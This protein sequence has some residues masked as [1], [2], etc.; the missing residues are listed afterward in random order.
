MSIE[1]LKKELTVNDELMIKGLI[2]I[3]N[4]QTMDE[5][6][7]KDVSHKNGM[8]FTT[9]DAFILTSFAQFYKTR[10]FLSPKQKSI[11]R[12]KIPKY[13]RQLKKI[14]GWDK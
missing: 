4:R 5:Q 12:E 9:G 10:G 14:S 3:Y 11:C 8:G 13:A 1:E 2:A 6:L 7:S